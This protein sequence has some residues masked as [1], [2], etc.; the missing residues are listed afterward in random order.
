MINLQV[1]RKHCV[2]KNENAFGVYEI[3]VNFSKCIQ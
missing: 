1:M 2:H 3:E